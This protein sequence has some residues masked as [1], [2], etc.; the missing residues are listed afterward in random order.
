[1]PMYLRA[2]IPL[3]GIWPSLATSCH[4]VGPTPERQHA[5]IRQD[6]ET[7]P[8]A[9]NCLPPHI[10]RLGGIDDALL[11]PYRL[12]H[13]TRSQSSNKQFQRPTAT[14]RDRRHNRLLQGGLD[15][16]DYR[17]WMSELDGG[18]CGSYC[19]EYVAQTRYGLAVQ[20]CTYL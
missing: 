6:F 12:G 17:F 14:V 16:C 1:M 8:G 7:R 18:C 20:H 13:T 9:V 19:L 4:S 3:F 2:A 15:R 11:D 10:P 5:S